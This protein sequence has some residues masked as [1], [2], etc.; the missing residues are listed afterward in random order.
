MLVNL[1]HVEAHNVRLEGELDVAE[2]DWDTRDEVIQAHEPL[3]YA[4]EAQQL[5]DALLI[6]GKLRIRLTCECVRCL[7]TFPFVLE[8]KKWACHIPLAGEESATV[9]NDCVDLTPYAREDILLELPQHPLCDPE[10]RGLPKMSP[11]EAEK[12]LEKGLDERVPSAWAVL[13]KLKFDV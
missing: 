2:L 10:C 4:L 12:A 3:E 8:L 1:R 9:V 11:G 7:K 5:E 6:Q 13:N